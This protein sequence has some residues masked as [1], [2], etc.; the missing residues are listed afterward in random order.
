MRYYLSPRY[1]YWKVFEFH[2]EDGP[3]RLEIDLPKDVAQEHVIAK[4]VFDSSWASLRKIVDEVLGGEGLAFLAS[5]WP[6]GNAETSLYV[7]FGPVSSRENNPHESAGNIAV[8][9]GDRATQN[10]NSVSACYA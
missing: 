2:L 1:E 9:V 6:R 10:L 3:S 8:R 5:L 4:A 7:T